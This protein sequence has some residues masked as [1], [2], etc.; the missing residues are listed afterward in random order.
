MQRY[1]YFFDYANYLLTF[2]IFFLNRYFYNSL[3]LS[4]LFGC[5]LVYCLPYSLVVQNKTIG[6]EREKQKIQTRGGKNKRFRQEKEDQDKNK[7]FRQEKEGQDKNKRF[8]QE[9][10][11]QDKNKR[12][13]Q[14]KGIQVKTKAPDK[15][16]RPRC[17]ELYG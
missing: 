2:C 8:R 13:G 6:Q 1:G 16:E 11:D 4:N 12:F 5:L 14:E 17:Q 10:E 15:R 3:L 7:R 9:K